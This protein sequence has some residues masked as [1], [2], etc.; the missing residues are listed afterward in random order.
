MLWV[1]PQTGAS[2]WAR[3]Y[4]TVQKTTTHRERRETQARAI[5]PEQLKGSDE[6]I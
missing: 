6:L 5:S 4:H 2:A 1:D 3:P